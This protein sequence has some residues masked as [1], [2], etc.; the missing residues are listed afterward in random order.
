MKIYVKEMNFGTE[1]TNCYVFLKEFVLGRSEE[2]GTMDIF[3]S[4]KHEE[5]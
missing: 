5:L 4:E 2:R 1:R 3:I